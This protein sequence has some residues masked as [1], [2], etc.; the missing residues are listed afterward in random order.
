MVGMSVAIRLQK[1]RSRAAK[2]CAVAGRAEESVNILA[3]SKGQPIAKIR[4]AFN[5]GQKFFAENYVQEVLIK[6]EQLETLPV[7][8]HF[9]GRIQSNKVKLL[10]GRFSQ[11]HSIDRLN[12]AATLDSLSLTKPQE[13]FLQYNVADESSKGG[14]TERDLEELAVKIEAMPHLRLRGLM[15]MPPLLE[16]PEQVRPFFKKARAMRDKLR[17]NELSMGTSAD[18]EVAIEEGATWIR[19]GTEIFGERT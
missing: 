7:D 2:A 12:I 11:I 10:A 8:W 14:A 3:V 19:I 5:C 13:I 18:F 17:L 15:V 16:N 1:I 4:E 9:I 6:L